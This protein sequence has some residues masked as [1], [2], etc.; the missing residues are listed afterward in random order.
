MKPTYKK[1]QTPVPASAAPWVQSPD[2]YLAG[3]AIT[4]GMDDL[5]VRME[6]KWGIGRLRLLVSAEWRL[7]FDTQREKINRAIDSGGVDDLRREA[8]RME[9]AWH[10][11]DALATE[12]GATPTSAD[13]WEVQD[14]DAMHLIIIV[15]D[16]M[17][18]TAVARNNRACVVYSLSEV[19]RILSAY[20]E[21][22]AV[23]LGFPGSVVT[24][25]RRK[26][27]PVDLLTRGDFDDDI[28]F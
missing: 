24:A 16:D 25:A 18:A 8:A 9:A 20:P 13:Q 10:K 23:K 1:Q 15:K 11:L 28:P 12:G 26:P 4:D 5:A 22:A 3:R 21:I 19:G 17:D 2:L 6:Q 14:H 27:D 7:K